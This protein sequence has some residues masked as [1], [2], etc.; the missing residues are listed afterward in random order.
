MRLQANKCCS[1]ND[2][3]SL[4]HSIIK[5]SYPDITFIKAFPKDAEAI[6]YKTP[7]IT[8]KII[9]RTPTKA[10]KPRLFEIENKGDYSNQITVQQFDYILE[11]SIWTENAD[12][13][14]ETLET[15]EDEV[16][17]AYIGD[18]KENGV[19]EIVFTEQREDNLAND[20]SSKYV[21]R[22]IRYMVRIEKQSIVRTKNIAAITTRVNDNLEFVFQ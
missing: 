15:F 17:Q 7:I 18:Y 14:D 16:I 19:Q 6:N 10:V 3:T 4:I 20:W 22:H 11:F 1:I 13:A 2:F 9:K 8:H 12:E 5:H 21:S